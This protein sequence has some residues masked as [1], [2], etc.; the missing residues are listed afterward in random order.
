MVATDDDR[1]GEFARCN[2]LIERQTQPVTIAE[3]DPAYSGR[4]TLEGN[5]F[6]RHVEPVVQMLVVGHQFLDLG[7]GL[8]DVFRI[9]GQGAP[10]ERADTAAKQGAD[11]GRYEAGKREGVF[12]PFFL[13]HLANIV[14]VIQCRYAG[15]PETDHGLD[16]FA[17]RGA[18]RGFDRFRITLPF[19][20][21]FRQRPAFRQVAVEWIVCRR[22]VC[23]DVWA[24]TAA[25]QFGKHVGRVAEQADG[26]CFAGLCPALDHVKRFVDT[27]GAFIDVSGAEAEIDPVRVAFDCEATGAGHGRGERLRSAHSAK[28]A[29]EDPFALQVAVVMLAA[30]FDEG[31]IGALDDPLG[32]DI[33]PAAR[34][35]LPVHHQ[36]ELIEFVEMIPVGP[37]RNQ[38]GIGDQHARRVLVGAENA[39]RFARLHQERFFIV[40]RL[41]GRCDTV[42]IVPGPRRAADTTINNEFMRFFRN[43]RIKIVHHHSVGRFGGP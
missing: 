7:V 26:L 2:H 1:G 5:A 31:F 21:P 37:M 33:D 17:H 6:T 12:K 11:I 10:A 8:V 25:D 14:A 3:A 27:V 35:H 38:V 24:H 18:G 39:D 19:G 43:L 42:E 23:D 40:Q 20:V 22:L 4:Q 34:R 15:V 29:G 9:A 32:P 36:A 13:G 16:L 30:G 28:A 41:Q